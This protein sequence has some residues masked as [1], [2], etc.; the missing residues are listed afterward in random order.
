MIKACPEIL[1]FAKGS[2]V[3]VRGTW[4]DPKGELDIQEWRIVVRGL[5]KCDW[6][7][8]DTRFIELKGI[9]GKRLRDSIL[10][11]KKKGLI[12]IASPLILFP[13]IG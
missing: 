2:I 5:P 7:D 8:T 6:E 12:M 1:L 9:E 11:T 13:H 3:S 4:V 10:P